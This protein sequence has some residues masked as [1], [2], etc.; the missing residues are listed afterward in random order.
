MFSSA[1][2]STVSVELMFSTACYDRLIFH[3]IMNVR[4]ITGGPALL[5]I[6]PYFD[7]ICL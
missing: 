3:V 7:F 5:L 6:F 2:F 1:Q 4:T